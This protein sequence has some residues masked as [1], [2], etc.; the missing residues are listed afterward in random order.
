MKHIVIVGILLCCGCGARTVNPGA[1]WEIQ[2]VSRDWLTAEFKRRVPNYVKANETVSGMCSP[3]DRRIYL[4]NDL[5]GARRDAVL[6]HEYTHMQE[7]FLGT[8]RVWEASSA[9][10]TK[11]FPIGIDDQR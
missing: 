5:H 9:L 7:Y 3:T 8:D 10:V 2:E 4:A 1:A 6:L 11:G